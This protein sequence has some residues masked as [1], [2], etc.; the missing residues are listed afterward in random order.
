MKKNILLLSFLGLI[1][2]GSCESSKTGHLQLSKADSLKIFESYFLFS[3]FTTGP[4]HKDTLKEFINAYKQLPILMDN[5][6]KN[7]K[8]FFI[9]STLISYIRDSSFSDLNGIYLYLA[10][11]QMLGKPL[12]GKVD[13]KLTLI[14]ILS[15]KIKDP[16][17]NRDTNSLMEFRALEWHDH[18]SLHKPVNEDSIGYKPNE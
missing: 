16:Q 5:N 3:P 6:G 14:A 18:I 13:G 4:L 1:I 12:G 8:G 11:K 9:D 15:R 17:T 10:R 2:L 7:A